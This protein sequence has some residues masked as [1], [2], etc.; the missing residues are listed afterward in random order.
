VIAVM[1]ERRAVVEQSSLWTQADRIIGP[2]EL[3]EELCDFRFIF[4]SVERVING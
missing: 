3:A 1:D 2:V 4:E